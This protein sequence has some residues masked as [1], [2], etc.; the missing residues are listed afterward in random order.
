MDIH[1]AILNTRE[2]RWSPYSIGQTAADTALS[3]PDLSVEQAL[4]K[5]SAVYAANVSVADRIAAWQD[6]I[7]ALAE[8]SPEN[9]MQTARFLE[10]MMSARLGRI[11]TARNT[12]I[13]V[14][15]DFLKTFSKIEAVH[16]LHSWIQSN[17]NSDQVNGV[18]SSPEV[19][20]KNKVGDCTE[21]AWLTETVLEALGIDTTVFVLRFRF[22][23]SF[24]NAIAGHA[25]TGLSF[26]E[27]AES[28]RYIIDNKHLFRLDPA[29]TW[30]NLIWQTYSQDSQVWRYRAVDTSRWPAVRRDNEDP[31]LS[32]MNSFTIFAPILR[33]IALR[34][35]GA[36][37]LAQY[38]DDPAADTLFFRDDFRARIYDQKK[39]GEISDAEYNRLLKIW[40]EHENDGTDLY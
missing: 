31:Q 34:E 9:K 22:D 11:I 35:F 33:D 3:A 13:A 26:T 27:N 14:L 32:N 29:E 28:S 4:Q 40:R 8:S 19:F 12:D 17:T 16:I 5:A 18:Y 38:F 30:K 6:V 2:L 36:A 39:S 10:Q 21:V 20:I 24:A 1:T 15:V 23:Y 37:G 7:L 25:F